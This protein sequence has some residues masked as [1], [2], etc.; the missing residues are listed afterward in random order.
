MDSSSDR[1]RSLMAAAQ[2]PSFR[3]LAIAAGVSTGAIA[4]LRQGKLATMQWATVRKI[5]L[6][7]G[8][9]MTGLQE[10]LEDDKSSES[11][12][13]S[14]R[15]TTLETEYA[16]LQAQLASQGEQV[17]QAVKQEALSILEPWLLQWPTATH[18]VTQNP[19]LPATRLVPLVK[20]VEA[21]LS[22]W[23]IQAIAAVGAE[24]PYDPQVHQ[25][26]GGTAA[27]GDPVR[28]R[29]SGYTQGTRLL[30]RAKVSPL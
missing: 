30:H 23:G 25:L 21:L 2:I 15:L 6:A 3:A 29:Y 11:T 12:N 17:Q 27:P 28:V 1:L 9:S 7:L 22:H 4:R 19:D 13:A 14:D 8:L 5:A 10:A 26:M 24:I 16:R 20:P 18:A